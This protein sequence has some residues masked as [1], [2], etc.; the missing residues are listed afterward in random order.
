MAL[1]DN[2]FLSHLETLIPNQ[3]YPSPAQPYVASPS[4]PYKMPQ[5][6]AIILTPESYVPPAPSPS[7]ISH[8]PSSKLFLGEGL[9]P[10]SPP[11]DSLAEFFRS[12]NQPMGARRGQEVDQKYSQVCF[13][14]FL[15]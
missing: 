5:P 14:S 2:Q 8:T 7:S 11:E 13:N 12:H 9:T 6:E 10:I 15:L 1:R 4:V 3:G